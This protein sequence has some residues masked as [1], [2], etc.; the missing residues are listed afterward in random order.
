MLKDQI[1]ASFY[2]DEYDVMVEGEGIVNFCISRRAGLGRYAIVYVEIDRDLD[3][4]SDI[5]TARKCISKC[6]N[7]M[8]LIKEVGVFLVIRTTGDIKEPEKLRRSVDLSGFHAVIIQGVFIK[9]CRETLFVESK[10][11]KHS[12][13]DSKKIISKLNAMDYG[14]QQ[15]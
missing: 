11:F 4:S 12:F 1:L 14:N 8:W 6:L 9:S 10:W 13:G 15:R 2:P 7:A 5:Y 3:L